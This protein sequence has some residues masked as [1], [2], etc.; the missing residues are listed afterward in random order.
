MWCSDPLGGSEPLPLETF[1]EVPEGNKVMNFDEIFSINTF[2]QQ[3]TSTTY[4]FKREWGIMHQPSHFKLR[5]DCVQSE[6]PLIDH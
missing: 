2:M 5:F 4:I 1:I 3:I 6:R